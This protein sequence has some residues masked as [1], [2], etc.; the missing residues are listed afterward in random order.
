MAVGLF[1]P[2]TAGRMDSYVDQFQAARRQLVMLAKGNR[3]RAVTEACKAHGGFYLGSIGGP[4]RAPGPGLHQARSRCSTTPS[5]AWRPCG[6]SRSR[7]SRRSSSSTTRATTSSPFDQGLGDLFVIRVAGNIVAPSQLGSVEFAIERFGTPLVVVLGHSRC[8]AI[9]ATV[10]AIRDGLGE[11]SPNIM[12]IVNRIR[13]AV[14]PLAA[15]RRGR[16]GTDALIADGV[17]AN[18]RASANQ[19]RHGSANLEAL[20]LDGRLLIVG[21]EYDLATGAVDFFDVPQLAAKPAAARRARA[22]RP[23]KRRPR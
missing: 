8:G 13:P 19:L 23:R 10:D 12:A 20:E 1:G 15:R 16:G 2:T 7:T 9:T 14:E 22:A 4:G 21:A 3:S 5:W 17:R 11:A 6:R 18:V